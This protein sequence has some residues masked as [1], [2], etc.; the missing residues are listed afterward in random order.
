MTNNILVIDGDRRPKQRAEWWCTTIPDPVEECHRGWGR[1]VG[2]IKG[3]FVWFFGWPLIGQGK[4]DSGQQKK[5][6]WQY[7][8]KI[9]LS[10]INT[11]YVRRKNRTAPEVKEKPAIHSYVLVIIAQNIYYID[12]MTWKNIVSSSRCTRYIFTGVF[13][14]VC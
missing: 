5:K 13:F 11:G 6:H 3:S 14:H 9:L 4:N 1:G 12:Y 7:R 8:R 2:S 10:I